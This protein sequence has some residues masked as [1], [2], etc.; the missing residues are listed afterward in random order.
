[1]ITN[2]I[3]NQHIGAVLETLDWPEDAFLPIA[4]EVNRQLMESI[5]V[6][7]ETKK[8]KTEYRNQLIDRVNL[9]KEHHQHAESGVLQN[10]VFTAY[11]EFL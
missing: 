6:N 1:M 5:E 10:L 7:I 8:S 2:S 9:L 3:M 11:F 4:N